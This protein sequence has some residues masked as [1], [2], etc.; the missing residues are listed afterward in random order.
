MSIS[1]FKDF[2]EHIGHEIV[3]TTYGD[4]EDPINIAIECETCQVVLFDVSDG[5]HYEKFLDE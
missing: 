5:E 3:C 1:D 4:P 2:K